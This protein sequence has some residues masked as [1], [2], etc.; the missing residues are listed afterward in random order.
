[1]LQG[2]LVNWLWELQ[3]FMDLALQGRKEVGEEWVGLWH[4]CST[5]WWYRERFIEKVLDICRIKVP[6]YLVKFL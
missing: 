4:T 2:F 5:G 3:K 1:M 6:L